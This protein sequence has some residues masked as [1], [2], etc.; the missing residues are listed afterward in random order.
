[1]L[2]GY[3]NQGKIIPYSVTRYTPFTDGDC[4]VTNREKYKNT[5]KIVDLVLNISISSLLLYRCQNY[6]PGLI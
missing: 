4:D 6:Y 2:F 1:M 3:K 5:A